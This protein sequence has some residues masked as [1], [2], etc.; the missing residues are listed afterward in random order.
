[1][2]QDIERIVLTESQI[3]DIVAGMGKQIS[4]DYQGK[5]LLVV[6]VL[7]GA[8]FLTA[9]LVR[10]LTIPCQ[11]DFIGVSSYGDTAVSGT[12]RMTKDLSVSPKGKHILLVEDVLDTGRTLLHLKQYLTEQGAESVKICTMLDKAE[13]HQVQITADY[14]GAA[15]DNAFVVGYGL[16]YAQRYRNLPY[17]GVLRP[18]VYQK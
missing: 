18:A 11:M 12:L 7:N 3:A 17:I 8:V 5:D 14:V 9:D 15:A 13:A 16:D 2:L 6:G 1:M 10:A 4:S